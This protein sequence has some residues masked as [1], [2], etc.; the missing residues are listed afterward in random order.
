MSFVDIM[1]LPFVFIYRGAILVLLLPYYFVLGIVKFFE[2]IFG[3]KKATP[4]PKPKTIPEIKPG[5]KVKVVK[6][7]RSAYDEPVV[8]NPVVDPAVKAK[9]L[10]AEKVKRQKEFEKLVAKVREEEKIR[11]KEQEK[12]RKERE[13]RQKEEQQRQLERQK[14]KNRKKL[15][16][17]KD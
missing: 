17:K 12:L 4:M 1:L 8:K 10:A 11:I 15:L 13:K 9:E 16:V 2:L 6:G 7:V 14:K 5:E 3:S